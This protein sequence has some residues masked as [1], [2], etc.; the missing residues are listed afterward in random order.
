MMVEC[1]STLDIVRGFLGLRALVIGDAMLDSYLEGTATRLCKEG[2][3]P[4]VHKVAEHRVPGGAANTAANLAALGADVVFVG[5]VGDDPAGA[6]LRGALAERGV[7]DRWL[8]S[9]EAVSTL[10]K[11]RLLANDQY[12]VRFDEGET[13]QCSADAHRR[14]LTSIDE[15]FARC[16]LVVVSDYAYGVSSDRLIE[17]LRELRAERRVPLVIDSKEIARFHH[18]GATVVTPNLQE[19]MLAVDPNPRGTLLPIDRP[20]AEEITRRLI[21]LLDA[22]HVAVTMADD[23]VLLVDREGHLTHLPAHPVPRAGDVGAGDSFTAALALA[24]ASGATCEQATRIGIDA[25]AIAITRRGT[26]VVSHQE[27]L[28]RASLD[29][30]ALPI[31]PKEL[32]IRLDVER[33]AGR[34]IVFTNGVFDI[35]HAGHVQLLRRAK[36]LGDLLVVGVNS[37]ASTRRLKGPTRPINHERDRVALVAALDSVDYAILFEEDTP[38]ET[39]RTVRPDVH[40][41]GGDYVAEK[42][43]EIDAVREVGARI[44]IL[45]LVDGRSTTNVI[46]RIASLVHGGALGVTP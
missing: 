17:R 33:F 42:L 31:S 15:S 13:R 25:A 16:D 22:E 4:V 1:P 43:P 34:T 10:H 8:V 14:L 27:L 5:L 6:L 39:I 26:S 21:A 29:D 41:K 28:R 45:S 12:V 19:A 20:A 38:A 40:V 32:A 23:G 24:L 44:E 9:D 2:P 37:D 46:N 18:A 7:D 35:L 30:Q 11:L 3:V 36:A